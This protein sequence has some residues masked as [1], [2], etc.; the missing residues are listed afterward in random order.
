MEDIVYG[1]PKPCELFSNDSKPVIIYLHGNS[2]NRAGLH[3]IRLYKFLSCSLYPFSDPLS[4]IVD[5]VLHWW[6]HDDSS[7]QE[8]V[9]STILSRSS[10]YNIIESLVKRFNIIFNNST[11]FASEVAED[12]GIIYG[13]GA[14]S[15]VIS[16]DYR[17]FGDNIPSNYKY[18]MKLATLYHDSIYDSDFL[19]KCNSSTDVDFTPSP[20]VLCEDALA[21]W[22]WLIK[23]C[24]I[25]P[26]RIF[27]FGHS[28][29]TGILA[30]LLHRIT[31]RM[32]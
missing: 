2:S 14:N 1:I 9:A 8:D 31:N 4:R 12:E 30:H 21:V 7:N 24:H 5:T 22:D 10:L 20:N 27:L 17:Q 13:F 32:V 29:G 26:N 15:H 28:L 16:F 6:R 3:R 19:E 25:H 11:Q 18:L 23:C